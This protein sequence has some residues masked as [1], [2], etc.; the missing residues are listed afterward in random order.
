MLLWGMLES[1]SSSAQSLNVL[2]Q[3]KTGG[4]QTNEGDER[5][6]GLIGMSLIGALK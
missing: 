3:G 6:V 1:N 5:R 2:M 4:F